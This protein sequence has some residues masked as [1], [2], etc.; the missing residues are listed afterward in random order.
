MEVE[1]GASVHHS[2]SL[3]LELYNGMVFSFGELDLR[4]SKTKLLPKMLFSEPALRNEKWGMKWKMSRE[5]SSGSRKVESIEY[6]L[7]FTAQD[8]R[9][10]AVGSFVSPITVQFSVRISS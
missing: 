3:L 1:S 10:R 6:C 8:G 4:P 9:Q 2:Y 5:K 7:L